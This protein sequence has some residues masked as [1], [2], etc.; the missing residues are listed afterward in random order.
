MES[1]MLDIDI[2]LSESISIPISISEA[3]AGFGSAEGILHYEND[4]LRLE[5]EP[6]LFGIIDTGLKER[7]VPLDDLIHVEFKNG[8]IERSLNIQAKSLKTFEGI[9]GSSQGKL[10][11]AISKD[12][13]QRA[14]HLATML[15]AQLTTRQ[16]N[17]IKDDLGSI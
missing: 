11:L 9:P 6:K 14:G 8:W 10:A 3:F 15:S 16:L 7:S 1:S 5:I 2:M 12:D 4:I 13:S 17:Q